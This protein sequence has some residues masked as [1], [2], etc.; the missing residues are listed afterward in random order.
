M[1]TQ[2][3]KILEF[4]EEGNLFKL[5]TIPVLELQELIDG[6]AIDT[7]IEN[8]HTHI[9]KYLLNHNIITDIRKNIRYY[10]LEEAAKRGHFFII[11]YV[12]ERTSHLD[13]FLHSS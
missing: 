7:V 9:L 8:G 1:D 10:H 6:D 11:R 2:K 3:Y 5:K 12:L 4:C 13:Y